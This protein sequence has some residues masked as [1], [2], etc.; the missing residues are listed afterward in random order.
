MTLINKLFPSL[1]F[2]GSGRDERSLTHTVDFI[3]RIRYSLQLAS[4]KA[5][6]I[7]VVGDSYGWFPHYALKNGAKEVHSLDIAAPSPYI[8]KLA[9]QNK[10]F[11]HSVSSIL[12]LDSDNKYS[13]CVFLEVLEHLPTGTESKALKNIFRSLSPGGTLVLSTPHTSL[14]SYLSDPALILGH[15]HYSKSKLSDLLKTSGFKSIVFSRGGYLYSA[16]D[17]ILM[18]FTKW[19]LRLPY[20]SPLASQVDLEYPHA[21]G[22]TIFAVCQK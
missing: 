7:L 3:G 2:S 4:V 6:K 19:I 18:Y 20:S 14:L 10:N 22:H 17:V 12:D 11:S 8:S 9:T 5:K 15:R 16:L 1:Y 13:L 21:H